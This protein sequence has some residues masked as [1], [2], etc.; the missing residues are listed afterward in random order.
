MWI[1]KWQR[2]RNKGVDSP[3]PTQLVS[4]EELIPRRQ[5]PEQKQVEYLI[6]E[7]AADRSKKL[8]MDR[9]AFMASSMGLATCFLASNMVYGKNWDVDE[10]E[11]YEPEATAEKFPKGEYFIIDVQS[12]FTNGFAIPG[13]R[14]AE[15]VKNMGFNLKTDAE[16]Y[17]F[18]NFV[19]E[20]FFDSETSMVVISG[21]PGR[22]INKDKDGKI[23]EGKARGGGI[24]P[25]WLMSQAGREINDLAGC[26]RALWQGN[27][28]PNHYWDRVNNRP[29]KAAIL[30]QMDREVN[31]YGIK[32]WKWYCHTDPGQ[33]G[34]GFQ[35]DD[36]NAMWFYRESV[37]RG[38]KIFSVHKGFSY[39]SRTLGHL[40]NPKDMEK[41]ALNNPDIT[42]IVYHSA[43]QHGPN[44]PNWKEA[45]K[46]DPTTGDFAWHNILMDIKRR[47][48]QITN[49]NCELGSFFNVLA[50][51]DPIMC[52]HGVGKNVKYYGADHVIWGTDCLWWGSPQWCI[53]AFKRFQISDELCERFGY[54][55]LTKEDKAKIF[56]L[57]AARIYGIDVTAQRKALPADTLERL[58]TAYLEG[59][60]QR[61]NAAYGWV[62]ADD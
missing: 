34:G 53:D 51:A 3:V 28:A 17:G 11:T 14:D 15:F 7:L 50:V 44:E 22:E 24:L 37:K 47:N 52:Q 13:F 35:C 23:L 58:K 26:Q 16:A 9:R 18:R 33:S 46:W 40:A 55:K 56:G 39:Q 6:G 48:P 62:R 8:G 5:T 32:S 60:G 1:R 59:G 38:I 36:D 29:D 4:N 19:K 20:M 57:N 45:N 27:L 21:V 12:H 49:L 10:V 42:F 54:K 43:L 30:D 41:A 2:D 25:S 61:D 31:K